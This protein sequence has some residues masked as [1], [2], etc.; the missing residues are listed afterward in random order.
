MAAVRASETLKGRLAEVA[1]R[2]L[3]SPD[4]GVAAS[5]E[6]IVFEGGGAVDARRPGHRIAFKD[7][8]RRAYEERVDLGARGF[9]A[10]PGVDFNRETGRG[11]PFLYYT[12]GAAVAE[13]LVD[14][15]TGSAKVTRV[16]ILMDLGRSINPAV[17]RGQVVGGFV[18]GLGWA[19][20]E[21]LRY[22]DAGEL[23]TC[24][25]SNYKIP[26]VTD[27]PPDFRVAFLDRDNPG[28]VY[29][30][31]AVGEPPFVL[32]IAVWAAIKDALRGGPMGRGSG[33]GLPATGEAI[34]RH[35]SNRGDRDH[36]RDGVDGQ[37]S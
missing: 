6:H 9:Y 2:L 23:L 10:T 32:G 4:D 24:S 29:G 14:R 31:K 33:L 1:S 3:A 37:E 30:S 16:D 17:D 25:P 7:L 19:T 21:E 36:E 22:S 8:V 15:L 35:L 34:L 5:A 27:V 12:A 26:A 18:Q 11:S 20:T 28:N 13:V